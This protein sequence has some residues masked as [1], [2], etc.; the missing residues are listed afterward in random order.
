MSLFRNQSAPVLFL[1]ILVFAGGA[2]AI[3]AF[4]FS[5]I[6]YPEHE[7][8][9]DDLWTKA[10]AIGVVGMTVAGIGAALEFLLPK[11]KDSAP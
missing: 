4:T 7:P 1:T 8:G 5:I 3:A 2:V 9:T 11:S 6:L 10:F